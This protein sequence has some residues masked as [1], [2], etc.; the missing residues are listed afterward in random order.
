MI[1][2]YAHIVSVVKDELAKACTARGIDKKDAG[3][4]IGGFGNLGFLFTKDGVIPEAHWSVGIS[5][6]SLLLGPNRR[7]PAA[8]LQ[9]PGVVP[10]DDSFRATVRDLV[11]QV[12]EAR[13]KEFSEG[14]ANGTAGIDLSQIG[15][16]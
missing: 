16:G 14:I 7:V 2:H 11:E 5:L 4:V 9:V 15:K 13:K 3:F 12:D 8:S 10:L 6:R 1:D